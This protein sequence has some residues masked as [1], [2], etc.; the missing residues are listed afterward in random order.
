[1]Y[2][3][4]NACLSKLP[5]V[6]WLKLIIINWDRFALI[7]NQHF[8]SASVCIKRGIWNLVKLQ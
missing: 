5:T 4:L 6:I 1:M 2:P 8:V 3:D 7:K